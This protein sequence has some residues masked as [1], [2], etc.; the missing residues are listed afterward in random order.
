MDAANAGGYKSLAQVARVV[1][2]GWAA[3]NLYC[4]ACDADRLQQSRA[5]SRAIDFSCVACGAS[6]QLKSGK[7]WSE[8]RI[9]DAAYSAMMA[10]IHSD[11]TP[12]LLVLHYTSSWRVQN[13]LLV[14]SFFFTASAV[15]CRKPLGPMARRAGWIGCNILLRAIAPEGKLRL[16]D[17]GRVAQ[18]LQ[19]RRQY[20]AIKPIS[21][22]QPEMRGW[23]L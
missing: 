1:T 10:A 23:T 22:L 14:P 12:N 2:E 4:A 20:A 15:E 8:E 7:R 19:V 9:P 3:Q 5:N 11:S 18:P 21:R 13:L 6:Y 17:R 16:V